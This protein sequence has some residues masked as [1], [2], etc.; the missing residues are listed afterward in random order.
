[1]SDELRSAI[2]APAAV[3]SNDAKERARTQVVELVERFRR[4]EADYLQAGY[5]ETQ[6]RT[7]FITPLLEAFG[8]DV[9]NRRAQP[10]IYREV[11]E[12]VSYTHLTLP[13]KR[14]V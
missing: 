10:L 9:H 5:N 1:M 13:T 4:N 11:I 14:I 2:I 12:A 6:A 8:W 3:E 7:E